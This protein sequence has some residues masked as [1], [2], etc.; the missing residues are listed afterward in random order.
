MLWAKMKGRYATSLT[1]PQRKTK[2]KWDLL[3]CS[4]GNTQC[5]LGYGEMGTLVCVHTNFKEKN[6]SNLLK[7][8]I[9][10]LIGRTTSGSITCSSPKLKT[11]QTSIDMGSPTQ[12][13]ALLLVQ[14]NGNALPFDEACPSVG[15]T[16][17]QIG[18]RHKICPKG[19]KRNKYDDILQQGFQNMSSRLNLSCH[20]FP[21]LRVDNDSYTFKWL[22]KFFFKDNISR[23]EKYMELKSQGP[24]MNFYWNRAMFISL[25]TIYGSLSL[26]WQSWVASHET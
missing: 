20:F 26:R 5:W 17:A 23:C 15:E 1:G 8:N 22:G 7:L 13:R 6:L 11:T 9:F 12:I 14:Q 2:Q 19:F 25:H 4:L 10:I 24:Y 16:A 3:V 18:N 21:C